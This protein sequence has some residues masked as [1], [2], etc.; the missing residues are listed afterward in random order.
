MVYTTSKHASNE[1]RLEIWNLMLACYLS[2]LKWAPGQ[3]SYN[4]GQ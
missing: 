3:L 1:V 2:P 4:V